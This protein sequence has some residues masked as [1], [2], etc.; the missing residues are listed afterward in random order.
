MRQKFEQA[1]AILFGKKGKTAVEAILS[2][3][4]KDINDHNDAELQDLIEKMKVAT[5]AA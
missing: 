2:C 4:E 3:I 1:K 5:N